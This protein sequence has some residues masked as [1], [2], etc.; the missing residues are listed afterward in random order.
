MRVAD[1]FSLPLGSVLAMSPPEFALHVAFA[2]MTADE[3]RAA[4]R[5]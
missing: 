5:R 2:R 1:R 3:Q 4:V